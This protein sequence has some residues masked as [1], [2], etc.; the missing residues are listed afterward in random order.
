MPGVVTLSI[1][2]ATSVL[3]II[4]AV[5]IL[6]KTPKKNNTNEATLKRPQ[7]RTT[8]SLWTGVVGQNKA[9][10]CLEQ[11]F[12]LQFKFPSLFRGQRKPGKSALLFGPPGTGKTLLARTVAKNMNMRFRAVSAGN[13]ISKYVGESV[14]NVEKLF[15]DARKNSPCILFFDEI[16]SLV[17][18]RDRPNKNEDSS[19]M[20]TVFLTQMDGIIPLEGVFVLAAT[21][22]P[23]DLDAAIIR[24]FQ[25]RIYVPLPETADRAEMLKNMSGSVSGITEEQFQDLAC[26]TEGFSGSDIF[27]LVQNALNQPLKDA[28]TATHFKQVGEQMT[29]CSPEDPGARKMSLMDIP[30]DNLCVRDPTYNDFVECL[31]DVHPT[32]NRNSLMRYENWMNEFGQQGQ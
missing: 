9:K 12:I 13:V 26:R 16:D 27:T 30:N 11:S 17:R 10:I 3:G 29:P 20:L 18:S 8:V 15:E 14:E 24:R 25:A 31:R 21:N 32:V 23:W 28:Q 7:K 5:N 4:V 2:A 6:K 1:L 19:R 22:T